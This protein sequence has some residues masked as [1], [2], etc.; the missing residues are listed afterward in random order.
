MS[1]ALASSA[2]VISAG[3]SVDSSSSIK[4]AI[5]AACGAAA[6]VP[7]KFGNPSGSTS[8][9]KKVVFVPSTQVISGFWRETLTG[10]PAASNRIGVGPAE[11][12]DSSSG[13]DWAKSGVSK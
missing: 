6:E 11:E 8:E 12:N 2:S 3:V 4:A 10:F 13:G 9:P 1:I 5:A 7:K